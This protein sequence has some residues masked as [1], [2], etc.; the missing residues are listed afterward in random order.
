MDRPC[1]SHS[2]TH[3]GKSNQRSVAKVLGNFS[4]SLFFEIPCGSPEIESL[5]HNRL[6]VS[7]SFCWKTVSRVLASHSLQLVAPGVNIDIVW[8]SVNIPHLWAA[9]LEGR[10]VGPNW[11]HTVFSS[12]HLRHTQG[13]K[14]ATNY[15]PSIWREIWQILYL[16]SVGRICFFFGGSSTSCQGRCSWGGWVWDEL[17]SW[18]ILKQF[19]L[20]CSI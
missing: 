10:L 8:V 9:V 7:C 15:K 1:F 5:S 16:C 11:F 6:P 17:R 4:W 13:L 20:Q 14:M 3:I 12:C 18:C 2:K 19:R